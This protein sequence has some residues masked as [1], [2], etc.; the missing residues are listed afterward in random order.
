MIN[1]LE[2][3]QTILV[4]LLGLNGPLEVKAATVLIRVLDPAP[5]LETLLQVLVAP[6]HDKHLRHPHLPSG[7]PPAAASA[8]TSRSPP[9]S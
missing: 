6:R 3:L 9:P 1:D 7:P 4:D 5:R 2:I 8:S